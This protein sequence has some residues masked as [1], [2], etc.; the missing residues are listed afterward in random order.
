[1]DYDNLGI[2]Y[3]ASILSEAGIKSKIVDFHKNKHEILSTVKKA[4]PHL[5][6]FSILFHN[7]ISEFID[8]IY[9]LRKEGISCHFTAGGHYASLKPAELFESIPLL[10]SI[11]RF[12]GEYTLP[13]LVKCLCTGED[14]RK[15]KNLA[16]MLNGKIILNSLRPLEKDL[17]KFPFPERSPL[18]EYAFK[19]KFATIL[20][21][22]GCVHNCS[23]CNTRE[24]YRQ[25]SGPLKRIRKPEMVIR[26]MVYLHYKR[27]CSVFL[28]QDDDF[29]VKSNLLPDWITKFCKEIERTGLNKKVIWKI[30]CRPDEVEEE[31]FK[32]MKIN[33]LYQVFLGIEDGTDVGLKSLNKQMTVE[34]NLKGINILRK[35]NI[36]FDYGFILFQPLTTY[37]SLNENLDFLRQ[38][39]GDGYTPVTFLR[40]IPLYDTRV[41]KEL[42]K[43]GKLIVTEGYRDYSFPEESMNQ[44]YDFIMDCFTEWL[45]YADGIE[46]ISKWA[47]NY[48][49]VYTHYYNDN[50]A[51]NKYCK[52]ITNVIRE[53]NLFLLDRMKQLADIFEYESDKS[54]EQLLCDIKRKIESKHNYFKK[55]IINTMAKLVSL[56]ETL[57]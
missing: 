16:Y 27:G 2:G 31:I 45:R 8:L 38:I 48:C 5:I 33:G 55:E 21:G 49:S 7:H 4:D 46:N 47:R 40:L 35:L 15:T 52:K 32:L 50:P 14:W 51:G 43:A 11:V 24:Y 44:Y 42:L 3:M 22:R 12:E 57:A 1:M 36:D 23:F 39:C 20:A 53:S 37:K 6:G 54:N 26:E 34:K 41:E 10:D 9:Y 19:K 56:V 25:A 28:F 17:D 30:A 18:K 29:P 13:E